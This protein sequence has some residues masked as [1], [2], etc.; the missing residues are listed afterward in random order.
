MVDLKIGLYIS[1]NRILGTFFELSCPY[2]GGLCSLIVRHSMNSKRVVLITGAAGYLG[3]VL[4]TGLQDQFQLRLTDRTAP[5][6][7]PVTSEEFRSIELEDQASLEAFMQ[8][9]EAVVH[10][11]GLSV[12]GPWETILSANIVA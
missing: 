6:S 1:R 5:R 3:G 11:G 9:V 7:P 8:G 10:L 4:R 2:P 12:E